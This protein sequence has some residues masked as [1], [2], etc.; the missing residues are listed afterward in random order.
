MANSHL[1]SAA[2]NNEFCHPILVGYFRTYEEQVNS[3]NGVN[4]RGYYKS[5]ILVEGIGKI[6]SSHMQKGEITVGAELVVLEAAMNIGLSDGAAFSMD[7]GQSDAILD[8]TSVQRE[9]LEMKRRC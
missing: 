3:H 7:S 9:T 5:I 1:S 6:C 4:L 8:F 2:F